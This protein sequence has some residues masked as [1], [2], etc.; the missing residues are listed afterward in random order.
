MLLT[1]TTISKKLIKKT[2]FQDD[3]ELIYLNGI[4]Y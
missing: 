1:D 4:I 2:K 3:K